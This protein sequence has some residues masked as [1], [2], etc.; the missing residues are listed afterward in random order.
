M[1][2]LRR[3]CVFCGSRSGTKTAHADAARS[4]GRSL[5]DRQIELVFG[6]G[7]IGLMGTMADACL[8][9]GGVVRGVIPTQLASDEVAHDGLTELL[10][11]GSM[12]ERKAK[13][14]ELSDAFIAL[15]GG[16]GTLEELF[17]VLTWA[18][19]RIHQKPVGLFNVHGFFDPLLVMLDHIVAEGFLHAHHLKLFA[20]A[21]DAES[22]VEALETFE[23][24]LD[25][26]TRPLSLEDT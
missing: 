25:A 9:A 24:G 4:L 8:T 22:L 12:H 7:S 19:L 3:V 23:V 11:V 1:P 10:L 26:T 15:P 14:A 5:A 21:R 20:H 13:M 2:Q 6:G 18:Q 16:L 17:E